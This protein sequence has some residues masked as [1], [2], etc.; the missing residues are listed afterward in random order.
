MHN[1]SNW[2]NEKGFAFM[3]DKEQVYAQMRIV[4]NAKKDLIGKMVSYFCQ[5][6][7]KNIKF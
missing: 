7:W 2:L 4:G 3:H 1:K 5:I 6:K